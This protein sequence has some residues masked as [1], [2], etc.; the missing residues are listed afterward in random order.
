[1]YTRRF[2]IFRIHACSDRFT[3][4]EKGVFNIQRSV[5]RQSF[6][7]VDSG[8]IDEQAYENFSKLEKE[9]AYFESNANER[10][11]KGKYLAKIVKNYKKHKKKNKM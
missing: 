11:K 3:P 2:V 6:A 5:F 1:M 4:P 10:R 7:A 8:E 9:K